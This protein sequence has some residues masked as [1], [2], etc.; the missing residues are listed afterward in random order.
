MET[1]HVRPERPGDEEAI[2]QL[3]NAAFGGPAESRIIQAVRRA[4]FPAVSLVAVEGVDVVGHILFTHVAIDS[5]E[6][7][8]EVMGLGPMAVAPARQRRGIGSELVQEGL[9]A[10]ALAGCSAIVVLGHPQFYPRF[11]FRP[12]SM[13]GLRSE[14]SVPDEVFMALELVPG[15]LNGR[16]GLVRYLSEF[17]EA[18]GGPP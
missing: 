3:T 16:T 5:A 14:Y 12:A 17:G 7:A 10:C 4:G 6:P 1:V 2:A 13:Y 9:R 11:G 15:A 18:P 8:T